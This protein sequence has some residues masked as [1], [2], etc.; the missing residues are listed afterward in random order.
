MMNENTTM[1]QA[2]VEGFG[3][4]AK[5]PMVPQDVLDIDYAKAFASYTE[6]E[7]KEIMELANAIDVR[8]IDNVMSYGSVALKATFEQ[9]G[10][11]LKDERGSKAELPKAMM[12]S[13]LSC[14]NPMCCKSSSSN[15]WVLEEIAAHRKLKIVQLLITSCWQ[16]SELPAILG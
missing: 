11:F 13:T 10:A 15:L 1:T 8:K 6:Q 9:C 3:I 2:Q 14:R 7:Q 16:S 12:T 5:V 4:D